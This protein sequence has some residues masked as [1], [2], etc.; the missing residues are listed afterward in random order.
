MPYTF[1][2]DGWCDDAQHEGRPAITGEFDQDWFRST[3]EAGRVSREYDEDELVTLCG[4]CT[5][6]LL[7]HE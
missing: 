2:C 3:P 1:I 6:R 5:E 7:L 4:D